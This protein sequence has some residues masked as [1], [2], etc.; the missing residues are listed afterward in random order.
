MVSP[1]AATVDTLAGLSVTS[2]NR[3]VPSTGGVVLRRTFIHD[4]TRNLTGRTI[5]MGRPG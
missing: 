1:A 2:A 4:W 3:R 5:V